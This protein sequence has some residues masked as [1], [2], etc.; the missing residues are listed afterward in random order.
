MEVEVKFHSF[1]TSTRGGGKWSTSRPG[2][3]T[4]SK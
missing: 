3:F 1:L 4:T 2:C